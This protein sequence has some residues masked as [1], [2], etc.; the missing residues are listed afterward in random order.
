M[1]IEVILPK[2]GFTQETAEIVAWLRQEG[3]WVEKGDPIA[4]VTTDKVNMEVEAPASGVLSGLR[5]K[6][7]D[8]VPVTEVIAYILER[9]E[10]SQ[11]SPTAAAPTSKPDG[12]PAVK[13]TPLAERIAR[14]AGLDLQALEGTGPGGRIT[15]RDVEEA[16]GSPAGKVRAVPAARRRARELGVPLHQV[17]GTGP[18]GRVQ[19]ADVERAFAQ[20]QAAQAPAAAPTPAP[21]PA[22]PPAAAPS[23]P[24]P[25]APQPAPTAP[26]APLGGEVVPLVGMR[27]TIAQRLQRSAQE[28]PHI[29]LEVSAEVSNAEALRQRANAQRS[30]GQAKVSLTAVLVKAVAWALQR[31]RRLNAWFQS[32][33]QGERIVLLPTANVGVAVALPDGL[34]VPVVRNAEQKGLLQIAQEVEDLVSRARQG[35]LAP[36]DVQD[37]TFTVSNLGMLG[38][39]RFTAIINPPQVA[40]L[41]VGAVRREV[42][43][44][45]QGAVAVRPTITLTLCADHRAVDGAVGAYFLADLKRALEDPQVMLL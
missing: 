11:P 21:A 16:L 2:F 20:Q 5:Y 34:I 6:P 33:A 7:G 12:Q 8:V 30:E 44:D 15:R 38:I 37:G 25:T 29:H 22:V 18:Q 14:A 31:H 9:H 39:N 36:Q 23:A 45:E 19:T 42:T 24:P 10:V 32:D 27:R 35:K 41:A 1:P 3:D 43:A 40:I 26:L 13:A 17:T 28:A 4:E